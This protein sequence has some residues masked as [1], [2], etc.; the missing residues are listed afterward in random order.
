MT[1]TD[2]ASPDAAAANSAEAPLTLDTAPPQPLG[3]VD[4]AVLWGSLGVSLLL[5]VAAVFV[6]RP[7]GLPELA[8]IAALTAIVVGALV[9]SALLGLAAVPGARTGAPAMVLLR[10]LLGRRGSY[11]PTGLNL[12]QCLGWAALEVFV[13]AEVAARLTTPSLRPLFVVLAGVLATLMALRPLSVV[14]VL[15]RYAGWLVALATAYLFYA[16]LRQG[17][18]PLTRGSW[19][20]FWLA[21][22]VV[23]ALPASWAPLAADYAR[24]SKSGGA[25]FAGAFVGYSI[26]A[27]AYFSLGV[28]ALLTV[29]G[30]PTDPVGVVGALLALPV[31]ALALV[32]LAVDEVDEAFANVYSTAMSVHNI[33][34]R[35]DRRVLAVVVGALAT[36]LGLLVDV[37]A[38]ESF[39]LLIGS[40]FVPLFAVVAVDYFLL[41]R[42]AWDLSATSRGRLVLTI[43]WALGFVAYQLI[44]PGTVSWWVALWTAVREALGF[45]PA[46]WMSASLLSFAVAALATGV[47]GWRGRRLAA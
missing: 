4:Q 5:P 6:L 40:V 32:I 41:R 35:M 1:L 45:T 25:A 14:R 2:P 34:P 19:A 33:A 13:I 8:P 22:D 23:V 36:T 18:P 28:L 3:W 31:G 42:G 21:M 11:L 20:G 16:V 7:F 26:A 47:I 10:G 17:L 38:Y 37:I 24:H 27:I 46:P 15:R 30:N 29:V 44:N 43:P 39:L 9:G 12:V